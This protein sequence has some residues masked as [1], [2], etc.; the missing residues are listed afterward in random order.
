MAGAWT[1]EQFFL[2]SAEYLQWL[3]H[4][5]DDLTLPGMALHALKPVL[6]FDAEVSPDCVCVCPWLR[7][8]C[9]CVCVCVCMI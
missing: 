5:E 2:W 9:V 3:W 7:V 8:V 1:R 6:E 4:Q